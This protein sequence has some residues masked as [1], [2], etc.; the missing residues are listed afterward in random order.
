MKCMVSH[1]ALAVVISGVAAFSGSSDA[2][3]QD[4]QAADSAVR[5]DPISTIASDDIIVMARRQAENLQDVPESVQVVT[6]ETI[7]QL[8]VTQG[9]ELAKLAP[10]LTL[11]PPI[12]GS[13]NQAVTLRGVRWTISSGLPAIPIY[14]NEGAFFPDTG[15]KSL[16]DIGQIEVLRGPQGTTRG[17][18]SIS[19]AILITTKRPD[20]NKLE[21]SA[22]VQIAEGDRQN[23]QAAIGVP[24]IPGM[25]AVRLAGNIENNRASRVTSV[26]S[27]IE[28]K[29]RTRSARASVLFKPTD[30]VTIDAMYQY[31]KNNAA[32]FDQVAGTG[33]VGNPLAG[34]PAGYNGPP[35]S[36]RQFLAVEEAPS[37]LSEKYQDITLNASWDVLGHRL[38]YNFAHEKVDTFR[39]GAIDSGNSIPNFQSYQPL[40]LSRTRTMHEVRLSSIPSEHLIDYAVGYYRQRANRPAVGNQPVYLPGAFGFTPG[41]TSTPL[42]RYTLSVDFRSPTVESEDSFYANAQLHLPY[43]FELSGG[44]R[45]VKGSL[46]LGSAS[47]LNGAFVAFQNPTPFP[48]TVLGAVSSPAYAGYCDIAIPPSFQNFTSEQRYKAT[49]WNASL[50]KKFNDDFLAYAT[51]GTSFRPGVLDP[52]TG[53]PDFLRATKGEKATSYELGVKATVG[54]GARINLAVYQ[55]NYDGQLTTFEGIPYFSTTQLSV[56]TTNTAF[57]RNVDA[58]VRGVEAE[59]QL[60]PIPYLNLAANI[61]Y[62]LIK[63][64]GSA[65]LPCNDPS[66]PLS[67][68]NPINLCASASGQKIN[69]SAPFQATIFASYE[70]PIS[71]NLN[72][73]L[74]TNINFQGS[75][76][77]Y[78]TSLDHTSS[79]AIVDLFGGV[80]I[81]SQW[82]VGIYAKNLFDVR[83]LL[84]RNLIDSGYSPFGSPGYDAVSVTPRREAGVQARFHF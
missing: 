28:P 24:I 57:F 13:F 23:Y 47:T 36:A 31:V 14:L 64:A 67:A 53:L 29:I 25:L 6:G 37:T 81:G 73:Y 62:S 26:N 49:I 71:G 46:L 76:P 50:S 59:I 21:G 10:G 70:R 1:I 18:A 12:T 4:K 16:F 27:T 40:D 79:Y 41:A 42:A 61:S 32:N 15:L 11:T 69:P 84:T 35:I 3:A 52:T 45:H 63:T 82:D 72:G 54:R 48:C 44:V 39:F 68:S 83:K 55:I 74:R 51:V 30:T 9:E 56:S 8:A 34:I 66:R 77:N 17:A 22:Q 2:I 75:S 20:L 60:K 7:N 19:G 5:S 78:G 80:T 58:R 65:L 33:S 38:A 43:D